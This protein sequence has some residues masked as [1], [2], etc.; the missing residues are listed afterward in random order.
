M[1]VQVTNQLA[2]DEQIKKDA[3]YR[4]PTIVQKQLSKEESNT[5]VM[6]DDCVLCLSTHK[7]ID[8]CV[9]N[10]GHQVGRAC[11]TKWNTRV[12]TCPLCRANITEITE[13]MVEDSS[14]VV[15][16]QPARSKC[17]CK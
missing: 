11:L 4:T 12:P 16:E 7:M 3:E 8:A 1:N 10:C 17:G 9:I 13:Y 5:C 14:V 6:D 15:D 2:L